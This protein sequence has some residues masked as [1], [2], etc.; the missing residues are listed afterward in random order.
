MI[1]TSRTLARALAWL[2]AAITVGL[3]L[4]RWQSPAPG[5]R[6][7]AVPDSVGASGPAVAE[8]AAADP[9]DRPSAPPPAP[10]PGWQLMLLPD[11]GVSA[12]PGSVRIGYAYVSAEDAALHLAMQ[13]EGG[14]GP[15]S[16]AELARVREWRAAAATLLADGRVQVGPLTLEGADRWL[17]QAQGADGLRQ[18]HADFDAASAPATLAPILAAGLRVQRDPK[19]DGE[20]SLLLRRK[21]EI[22]DS[23]RWQ[24]L[25]ARHA[26]L[27]GAFDEQAWPLLP[28]GNELAP[29]PPQE[30][31]ALVLVDGVDAQ[32]AT[33]LLRGG[34][35]TELALDPL[36]HA[37]AREL[38]VYLT[39]RIVAKGSQEPVGDVDVIWQH[40]RGERGARSDPDGR[41]RFAGID[42]QRVQ[43][44]S[45]RPPAP[46]AGEL[47][48]WPGSVALELVIDD[49]HPRE[50]GQRSIEH[51]VELETL[52]WLQLRSRTLLLDPQRNAG[53]PYPIF[54]LQQSVGGAWQDVAA[55]HF[56]A[57]DG[58]LAVS[59]STDGEYRVAAALAPWSLA[60]SSVVD[61]RRTAA[62]GRHEVDL[63]APVGRSVELFVQ[64]AGQPLPR[65]QLLVPGPL[66][67]MP[68]WE[69]IADMDGRVRLDGVTVERLPVEIGG[70]AQQEVELNSASVLLELE[71]DTP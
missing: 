53:R 60:Y 39:L 23:I 45:L 34:T 19:L 11:A 69:A 27:A 20:V 42:R 40:A 30:L 59:L 37:V 58:G 14:A 44:F 21:G 24:A 3:L 17:L 50:R 28:G 66:R 48:R 35:W 71:T 9:Q 47:P 67:G 36:A 5:Y 65:A 55:E 2:L 51:L 46:A 4:W 56:I 10:L 13:A 1:R 38:A 25:L 49:A 12:L 68:P 26:A 32:Q 6:D 61:T 16:A 15:A 7:P 70:H 8:R 29:L 63:E 62:D 41:V 64:H 33:L 57:H 52:D 22:A 31:D 54:V 43:T 18:Y